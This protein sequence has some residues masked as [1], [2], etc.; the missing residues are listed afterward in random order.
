MNLYI[1]SDEYI[2]FESPIKVIKHEKIKVLGKNCLLVDLE[3]S[4][5]YKDFGIKEPISR[6]ILVDRHVPNSDRLHELDKFSIGVHVLIPK[7]VNHPLEGFNKFSE[8]FNVA[9]ADLYD[10][11]DAALANEDLG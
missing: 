8:L 5:D 9:W 6:F 3:K 10:N 2:S 11:Y 1:V 7:D 4:L